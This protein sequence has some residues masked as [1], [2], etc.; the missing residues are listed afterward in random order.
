M[1]SCTARLK[2][3]CPKLATAGGPPIQPASQLQAT[4]V[5]LSGNAGRK[6]GIWL[7]GACSRHTPCKPWG[8]SAASAHAACRML[9]L[10]RCCQH[11]WSHGMQNPQPHSYPLQVCLLSCTQA[12][13]PSQARLYPPDG[14][15]RRIL[16]SPLSKKVGTAA[17]FRLMGK[18]AMDC[19]YGISSWIAQAGSRSRFHHRKASGR[20]L[21]SLNTV[22][23]TIIRSS[24]ESLRGSVCCPRD[25]SGQGTHLLLFIF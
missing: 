8:P 20:Q 3:E 12:I 1:L 18:G 11:E 2:Q 25:A 5:C 6:L 14:S 13:K 7:G 21:V 15:S 23:A 17:A 9:H 4:H 16:T 19:A 22:Q 10:Y 24:L